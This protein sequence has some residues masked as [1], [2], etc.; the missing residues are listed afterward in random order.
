MA[1]ASSPRKRK[2]DKDEWRIVEYEQLHEYA[3]NLYDNLLRLAQ[4]SFVVNPVLSAAFAYVW[5]YIHGEVGT[6]SNA[7]TSLV[8][9]RPFGILIILLFFI[10]LLGL[11]YNLGAYGMYSGTIKIYKA[12]LERI[13]KVEDATPTSMYQILIMGTPARYRKRKGFELAL[14]FTGSTDTLTRGFFFAL[15]I[16][17]IATMGITTYTFWTS[18]L[19]WYQVVLFVLALV[20]MSLAA[21]LTYAQRSIKRTSE[22]TR[23]PW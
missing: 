19:P 5:L 3:R 9:P 8:V 4:L 12:I 20:V 15:S 10:S 22:H 1:I 23:F 16:G 14:K 6:L 21:M 13:S 2:I 17:W 18:I 7:S 11:F